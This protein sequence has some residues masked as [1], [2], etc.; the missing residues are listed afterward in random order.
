MQKNAAAIH[1]TKVPEITKKSQKWWG[2]GGRVGV[3]LE[4]SFQR[5]DPMAYS[6]WI[7]EASSPEFTQF[8]ETMKEER[9]N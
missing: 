1:F 8:P 3:G 5:R 6:I 4:I 9:K 7:S 2:K